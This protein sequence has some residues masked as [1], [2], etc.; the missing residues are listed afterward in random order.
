MLKYNYIRFFPIFRQKLT[1][2]FCL[3]LYE[4]ALSLLKGVGISTAQKLLDLTGGN[5]K[6]LFE[7]NPKELQIENTQLLKLLSNEA[8]ENALTLAEKELDFISKNDITPLFFKSNFYPSRLRECKGAPIILYSKGTAELNP[9]RCLSI[10]GTRQPTQQG[11]DTTKS[12]IKDIAKHFPNTLIISGLAYGIDITAHK[13]ALFHHLPTAAI[14]GHGLQMIY[15]AAHRSI[16]QR[17]VNEDG[18]L[19]TQYSSNTKVIPQ[20]FIERNEIVA[21][22]ADATLIIESK[23][24][25]GSMATAYLAS[26][27][28]R[29]VLAVPGGINEE[30]SKG[31]NALIKKHIA[32][33]VENVEDIGYALGWDTTGTLIQQNLL[34][35]LSPEEQKIT[36]LLQQKGKMNIDNICIELA[37]TTSALL[38]IITQLEF[39]DLILSHPGKF[40]SLRK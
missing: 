28:G 20:N 24:K 34:F 18:A 2:I 26:S 40:Y 39:K 32:A 22:M 4:I 19:L 10:V 38:P 17:I 9:L 31:C 36:T 11:I 13:S 1:H 6:N 16:A 7:F 15:P 25:G 12:L 27:Y 35:D 14:L 8:K 5:V 29:D 23:E 3:M 21:A 33:L 30:K 37:T